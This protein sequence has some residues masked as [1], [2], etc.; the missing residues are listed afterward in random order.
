MK[1]DTS[2]LLDAAE[3]CRRRADELLGCD[4]M[5]LAAAKHIAAAHT[6]EEEYRLIE[7]AKA[8]QEA[9]DNG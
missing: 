9:K 2:K 6:F 8:N 3:A 7:R 1:T 4:G 5:A